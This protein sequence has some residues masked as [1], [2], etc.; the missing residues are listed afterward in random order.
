MKLV[1]RRRLAGGL[2]PQRRR[3][4]HTRDENHTPARP[5]PPHNFTRDGS[6]TAGQNHFDN[7]QYL[8]LPTHFSDQIVCIISLPGCT[9]FP[10]YQSAC[11]PACLPDIKQTSHQ[12]ALYHHHITSFFHQP[13]N[14]RT[15]K[16]KPSIWSAVPG[17]APSEQN[18]AD[19]RHNPRKTPGRQVA[20]PRARPRAASTAVSCK[21]NSSR[22]AP[23]SS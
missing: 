22:I 8:N 21:V 20:S 19:T 23:T 10:C 18:T 11:L 14:N 2:L 15:I 3:H 4:T 6:S 17:T 1:R 7:I 5:S 9:V 12:V 13:I 16:K